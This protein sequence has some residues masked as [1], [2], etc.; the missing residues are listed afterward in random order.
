[1]VEG[2]ELEEFG[3]SIQVIEV[4]AP[5]GIGLQELEEALILQVT[6]LMRSPRIIVMNK[7][8]FL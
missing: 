4:A 2:I 5:S 6:I 8:K 7:R 1:M 3:G